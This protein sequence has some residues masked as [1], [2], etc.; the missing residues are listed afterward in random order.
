MTEAELDVAGSEVYDCVKSF[1]TYCPDGSMDAA[2]QNAIDYVKTK[3]TM[4]SFEYRKMCDAARA[5]FCD[6]TKTPLKTFR[7][8]NRKSARYPAGE[9]VVVRDAT[10]KIIG[11][12]G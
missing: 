7:P 2:T 5:A 10:G 11:R 4:N 8:P 9:K 6:I 12:Q 1:L 3:F